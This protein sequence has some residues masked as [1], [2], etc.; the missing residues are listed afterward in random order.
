[1]KDINKLFFYFYACTF[2]GMGDGI[3]GIY[4][5]MPKL[6]GDELDY[7]R[8]GIFCVAAT[9]HVLSIV[10]YLIS[11]RPLRSLSIFAGGHEHSRSAG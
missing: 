11:D 1:M 7:F 3:V 10:F 5:V 9:V 2:V 8:L 4:Y 6:S